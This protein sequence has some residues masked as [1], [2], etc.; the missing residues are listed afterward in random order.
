MTGFAGEKIAIE[1]DGPHHFTA[2]TLQ[3]T[4][5]MLARQK[6]LNARG[7]AVISVPFFRWSG[8]TDA[9]RIEWFKPVRRH[10][11][12]ASLTTANVGSI[13]CGPSGR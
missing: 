1:V 3:V 6:L 12:S 2:N 13:P 8:K 9:E 5:E 7:W 4:G 10:A 11:A